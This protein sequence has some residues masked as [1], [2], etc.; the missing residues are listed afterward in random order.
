MADSN[1]TSI[2]WLTRGKYTT[3]DNQDYDWLS[4]WKWYYNNVGYAYRSATNPK[5]SIC[6]HKIIHPSEKPLVSDHINGNRLDNR[7]SNLRT[8]TRAQNSQNSFNKTN[9]SGYKGIYRHYK[10]WRARIGLNN[11]YINLGLYDTPLEAALAYD[12]AALIYYKE[13]ACTNK[14][15]GN[16]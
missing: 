7:R 3:V 8:C 11:K 1:Y 16:L 2:I 10:R 5:R 13:F 6:M 4:Q 9:P 15:L 14:M 12:E